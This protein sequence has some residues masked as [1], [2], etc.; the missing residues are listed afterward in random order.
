MLQSLGATTK[1]C[2]MYSHQPARKNGTQL[3]DEYLRTLLCETAAIANSRPLTTENLNDN[4]SL[5]HLT[6]NHLKA[7]KSK[8]IL[9]PPRDF[10]RTDIYSRNAEKG[11]S[12]LPMCFEAGGEMNTSLRYKCVRSRHSYIVTFR[13]VISF[14]LRMRIWLEIAGHYVE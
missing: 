13:K 8:V 11:S 7:M 1:D 10:Q 14:F 12:T 5:E 3:D 2:Y 9:F 6:P 4:A